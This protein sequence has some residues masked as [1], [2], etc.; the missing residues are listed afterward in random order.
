[1]D[2]HDDYDNDNV[3]DETNEQ[4][5]AHYEPVEQ[6]QGMFQLLLSSETKY[7]LTDSFPCILVH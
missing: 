2:D 3:D 1:M 7:T 6:T 4:D 5:G